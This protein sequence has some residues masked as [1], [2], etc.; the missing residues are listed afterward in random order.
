MAV[1]KETRKLKGLDVRVEAWPATGRNR[2]NGYAFCPMARCKSLDAFK[3]MGRSSVGGAMSGAINSLRRHL[4]NVH[5][6]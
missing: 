1:A 2:F 4:I 5:N 3:A 6:L